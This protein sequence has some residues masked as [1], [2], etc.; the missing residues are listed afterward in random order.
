MRTCLA[1]GWGHSLG[2]ATAW[3]EPQL[4]WAAVVA[5]V[6]EDAGRTRWKVEVLEEKD[7]LGEEQECAAWKEKVII[8]IT[9]HCSGA[10]AD[11]TIPKEDVSKRN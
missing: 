1:A 8:T 11:G 3:V 4:G 5:S 9:H 7:V 6:A 10:C 2:G